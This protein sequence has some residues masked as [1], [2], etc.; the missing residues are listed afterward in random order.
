MFFSSQAVNVRN[1][2][3]AT[4]T[5]AALRRRP[6][7]TRCA[8]PGPGLNCMPILTAVA[9]IGLTSGPSH[10]TGLRQH[11]GTSESFHVLSNSGCLGVT[12]ALAL[13]ATVR[14]SGFEP[15]LELAG[16]DAKETK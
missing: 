11:P 12:A 15:K 16:D 4:A 14:P 6:G 3:H 8:G 13:H 2:A 9:P 5:P 1:A 7:I 10:V